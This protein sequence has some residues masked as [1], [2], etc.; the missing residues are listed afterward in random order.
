MISQT[1]I[2]YYDSMLTFYLVIVL[3]DIIILQIF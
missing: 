1:V 2:L 3:K